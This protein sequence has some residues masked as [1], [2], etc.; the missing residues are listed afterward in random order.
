DLRLKFTVCYCSLYTRAFIGVV[1]IFEVLSQSLLA[2]TVNV[3]VGMIQVLRVPNVG[4]DVMPYTEKLVDA[5]VA[6]DT[7]V[8]SVSNDSK[9]FAASTFSE[10]VQVAFKQTTRTLYVPLFPKNT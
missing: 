5:P 8:I 1:V 4:V 7:P 3:L 6:S 10:A 9:N 2:V